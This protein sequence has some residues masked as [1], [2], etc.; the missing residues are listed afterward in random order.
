[1][2]RRVV[3]VALDGFSPDWLE[4][5]LGE[6]AL[7]ELEGLAAHGVRGRLISTIPATTPVAWA[8]AMT[9]C[10]PAKTGITAALLHRPGEPLDQ[11]VGCYSHRCAAEPVWET[12]ALNG[13]SACVV[14]FPVS[15]PSRGATLRVDGAAGWGGMTCLHEFAPASVVAGSGLA[16]T[17]SSTLRRQVASTHANVEV[18]WCAWWTIE[19]QWPTG[20]SLRLPLAGLRT[21]RGFVLAVPANRALRS[22]ATVVAPSMWSSPITVT[23]HGRDGAAEHSFRIKVLNAGDRLEELRF[24]HTGFHERERHSYPPDRWA[25]LLDRIGPIEERTDPLLLFRG[26]IDVE[27]QFEIFKLNADWTS[28]AAEVLLAETHWKLV[29]LHVHFLDWAHHA[30]QGGIDP[31]HPDYRPSDSERFESLLRDCYQLADRVVGSVR[32]GMHATDNVIVLGDHG[33]DVH[34][35]T[36]RANEVLHEA[37]L[38]RWRAC[39]G[40]DWSATRVYGAGNFFWVNLKGREPT[41]IVEPEDFRSVSDRVVKVLRSSRDPVTGDAPLLTIGAP[42][43]LAPYG[44]VS[45][46]GVGDLVALCRS[47]YQ[48]RNDRGPQYSP[49]RFLREFSSG[50]D[51]SSPLESSL[52]SRIFAMGPSFRQRFVCERRIPIRDVAPTICAALGIS[53]A[54]ACEGSPITELLSRGPCVTTEGVECDG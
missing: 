48:L 21:E 9:G 14:K 19:C 3:V 36:F 1:M 39:G 22:G 30:L 46:E 4:R 45:G 49:T 28:R 8:T 5:F 31:R 51:H 35:T 20:A 52:E 50:H 34:H 6:G 54:P 10:D 53:A 29:I 2:G 47:G 18:L 38:L 43:S 13:L 25:A 42:S 16:R 27:T 17:S 26:E 37:G 24:F 41:G 7:R 40:I 12:A 15:Y 32:A 11:R 44:H 23:A 33:Q